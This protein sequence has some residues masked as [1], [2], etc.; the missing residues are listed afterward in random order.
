MNEAGPSKKPKV[1]ECQNKSEVRTTTETNN[2]F[3]KIF[4]QKP[5]C[6]ETTPPFHTGW[7]RAA[8]PVSWRR[9]IPNQYQPAKKHCGN[10]N[11]FQLSM[12]DFK[13]FIPKWNTKWNRYY[14]NSSSLTKNTPKSNQ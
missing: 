13:E 5:T 3:K 2:T 8:Y 1:S 7:K 10:E 14:Q 11:R 12:N 6:N 4:T 9:R